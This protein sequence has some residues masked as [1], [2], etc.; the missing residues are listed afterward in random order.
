MFRLCYRWSNYVLGDFGYVLLGDDE[1][2]KIVGMG[3][4]RIKLNN[5]NEWLLKDVRHIP[6]MK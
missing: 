2:W 6:T 3:K 1:P 4:V 5:G